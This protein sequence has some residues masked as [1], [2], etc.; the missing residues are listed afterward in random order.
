MQVLESAW[1]EVGTDGRDVASNLNSQEVA[2][3][4]TKAVCSRRSWYLVALAL[5]CTT[6]CAASGTG[7]AG[8]SPAAS[9]R[10][11]QVDSTSVTG[12]GGGPDTASTGTGVG[13]K[14]VGRHTAPV[15]NAGISR[16]PLDGQGPLTQ[17]AAVSGPDGR[18]FWGLSAGH[19][20]ITVTAAGYRPQTRRVLVVE[21]KTATLDFDLKP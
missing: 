13:G 3:S 20:E 16:T 21:G 8:G 5:L 15:A 10:S 9:D 11:S 1:C 12:D 14:V 19:W 4:P 2:M 7:T 18:Y 17:Q 6:G